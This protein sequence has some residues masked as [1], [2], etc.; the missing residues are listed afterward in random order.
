METY[1]IEITKLESVYLSDAISVFAPGPPGTG[2]HEAYPML[3]MKILSAFLEADTD[4][5]PVV[6]H[7]SQAELWMIREVAKSSVMIGAEKVG[8]NLLTKVAKGLLAV[9]ADADVHDAVARFGETRLQ[10]PGKAKYVSKL[11]KLRHAGRKGG[12]A[13]A[14][15]HKNTGKDRTDDG[16]AR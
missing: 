12:D 5:Q 6:I 1:P 13:H 10:E 7:V 3:L 2:D 8:L 4:G 15:D 14:A 11:R 16:A 9:T